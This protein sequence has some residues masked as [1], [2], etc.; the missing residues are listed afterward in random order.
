MH[1]AHS[2]SRPGGGGGSLYQAPP[3]TDPSRPGTPPPEQTPRT[4]APPPPP[5]TEWQ[6]GAKIL[7]CPKLRMRAV[8]TVIQC[9]GGSRI[10]AWGGYSLWRARTLYFSHPLP[11][12][13]KS[14]TFWCVMGV[15]PLLKS[16]QSVSQKGKIWGQIYF[17]HL[18]N[19]LCLRFALCWANFAMSSS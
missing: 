4:R 18:W 14:K 19:S 11:Q 17:S 1:T 15:D 6:T 12:R 16:D 3:G 7:P 13:I 9:K 2:S 8:I 10:P 5:W